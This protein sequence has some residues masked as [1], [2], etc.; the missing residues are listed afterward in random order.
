[1][2]II[3]NNFHLQRQRD[4]IALVMCELYSMSKDHDFVLGILF[5]DV[6]QL[7]KY[8]EDN[9]FLGTHTSVH[10]EKR[11]CAFMAVAYLVIHTVPLPT[12]SRS[13]PYFVRTYFL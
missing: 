1:M 10:C 6:V 9:N 13:R 4:K 2:Y 3:Y 7:I 11:F 5:F 12:F 8:D